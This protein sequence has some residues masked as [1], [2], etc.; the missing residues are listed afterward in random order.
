MFS[1][2]FLMIFSQALSGALGLKL[3]SALVFK[4]LPG[5]AVLIAVGALSLQTLGAS[6]AEELPVLQPVGAAPIQGRRLSRAGVTGFRSLSH[7]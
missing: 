7:S 2:A 6:P 4:T 5:A 3:A 1:P